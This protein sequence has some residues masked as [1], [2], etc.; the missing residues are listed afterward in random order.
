MSIILTAPSDPD[1]FKTFQ[2][3]SSSINSTAGTNYFWGWVSANS[4]SSPDLLLA[5]EELLRR[6]EMTANV[7]RNEFKERSSHIRIIN[8]LQHL[9]KGVT[10]AS[11]SQV[12]RI[13]KAGLRGIFEIL[14]MLCSLLCT[15]WTVRLRGDRGLL[16]GSYE[17]ICATG[18]KNTSALGRT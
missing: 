15:G 8:T 10:S 3:L 9:D 14:I 12:R 5:Y 6:G 7:L 13:N 2:K 11:M 18:R 1:K 17:E 4:P 16:Q